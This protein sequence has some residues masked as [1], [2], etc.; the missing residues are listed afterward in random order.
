MKRGEIYYIE[1]FSR[2]TG[3]EQ[4]SGRPAIIVSNDKCNENSEVLEVVFLTTRPKTD[5]PTHVDIRSS[6][7]PSIALCEQISSVSTSRFGEYV[8]KCGDD[9]MQMIDAALEI[10]LGLNVRACKAEKTAPEHRQ[11]TGSSDKGAA[12]ELRLEL[13]KAQTER[14]TLGRLYAEMLERTVAVK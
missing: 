3:S 6:V 9:E 13:L 10:S 14:D 11:T 4:Q 5:L 7:K 1:K 8:G 2:A 12:E